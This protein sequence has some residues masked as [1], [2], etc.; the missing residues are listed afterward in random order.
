M[1]HFDTE[2]FSGTHKEILEIALEI[3]ERTSRLNNQEID[4]GVLQ[5]IE[6]ATEAVL[7]HRSV[8]GIR[9][10][11]NSIV[12]RLI[13]REG[14]NGQNPLYDKRAP[15]SE[16][17]FRKMPR[18]LWK[19]VLEVFVNPYDQV[20]LPKDMSEEEGFS[21]LAIDPARIQS[22]VFDKL[23]V[24]AYPE[25]VKEFLQNI[26]PMH[27]R[28]GGRA[29]Q[30][31]RFYVVKSGES[32]GTLLG[33]Q[34]QADRK[35]LYATDLYGALMRQDHIL[36]DK[37]DILT[38]GKVEKV[39]EEIIREVTEQWGTIRR[40]RAARSLILSRLRSVVRSLKFAT[41]EEVVRIKNILDKC[42][43]KDSLG[44][45]NP[46]ALLARITQ[47]LN[48][49]KEDLVTIRKR[50]I[51]S[52]EDYVMQDRQALMAQMRQCNK[53]F[54]DFY[55]WSMRG[56]ADAKSPISQLLNADLEN[57]LNVDELEKMVKISAIFMDEIRVQPFLGMAKEFKAA[58]KDFLGLIEKG[59]E[60][61]HVSK[62]ALIQAYVRMFT[63][64]KNQQ[65]LRMFKV[66]GYR[67]SFD[68][69][70][71]LSFIVKDEL[72]EILNFIT[73]W[74][75]AFVEYFSE[76]KES[77]KCNEYMALAEKLMRNLANVKSLAA[78]K[79]DLTEGLKSCP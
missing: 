69:R 4:A 55:A 60:E 59:R 23:G 1:E 5:E 28:V 49:A 62:K 78:L 51:E 9:A 47:V 37:S 46:S 14:K 74:P 66:L 30:N 58:A 77:E 24:K 36:K 52:I 70:L 13:Q 3:E 45:E 43:V 53:P 17:D 76:G 18:T 26:E 7:Q 32:R 57:K 35:T 64:C 73:S 63:I 68:T 71:A 2:Q 21:Y 8:E 39:V 65:V 79:K 44:R 20:A 75:M 33:T 22:D 54:K 50:Q 15:I 67:L 48:E 56:V 11:L 29:V 41:A 38:L 42:D 34:N 40:N 61:G 12:S 72:K 19:T 10:R 6:E 25:S 16:R 27:E 31:H